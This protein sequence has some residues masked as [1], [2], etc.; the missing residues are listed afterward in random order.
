MIGDWPPNLD[1]KLSVK[2]HSSGSTILVPTDLHKHKNTQGQYMKRKPQFVTWLIRSQSDA[3]ELV[4]SA[5]VALLLVWPHSPRRGEFSFTFSLSFRTLLKRQNAGIKHCWVHRLL[6]LSANQHRRRIS[7]IVW[8]QLLPLLRRAL[9]KVTHGKGKGLKTE[10]GWRSFVFWWDLPFVL[11]LSSY[12][13]NIYL[14]QEMPNSLGRLL[15][16]QSLS[17]VWWAPQ[18]LARK[19]SWEKRT[20]RQLKIWLATYRKNIRLYSELKGEIQKG[21][22]PKD[23]KAP[24][25]PDTMPRVL[26]PSSYPVSLQRRANTVCLSS[27]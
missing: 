13:P 19:T 16:T 24:N 17:V 12:E 22:Y 25:I 4:C 15:P 14:R 3:Q 7:V 8:G 21:L 23:Q 18:Q 26:S 27:P 1:F 5:R 2:I 10:Q 6:C 9:N 11:Y 20:S